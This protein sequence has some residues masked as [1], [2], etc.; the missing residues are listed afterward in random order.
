MKIKSIKIIITLIT[1]ALFG[2]TAIQFYWISNSM[3]LEERIF[4]KNVGLALSNITENLEKE[5]TAQ[6]IIKRIID[7]TQTITKKN[8]GVQIFNKSM[9]NR[10]IDNYNITAFSSNND[11]DKVEVITNVQS[12]K[13]NANSKVLLLTSDI[14]SLILNKNKIIKKVFDDFIINI[15]EEN[16]AE[17]I[18]KK[19]K[20]KDLQRI[21]KKELNKYGIDAKFNFAIHLIKNDSLFFVKNKNEI[22]KLQRTKYKAR[23]F[24]NDVFASPN[25]LIIDFPNKTN[26][27]YKSNWLVLIISVL[28]TILIIS[29]FYVTVKMFLKQKKITEVKNDLLNNITHE[30]KTPIS[31]IMLATDIM[32][33]QLFD[34]GQKSAKYLS[35]IKKENKRLSLIVE[36]ILTAASLE[37]NEIEINT[38]EIELTKTIVEVIEQFALLLDKK[39]GAIITNFDSECNTITMD[40]NHLRLVIANLIDNALKYNINLPEIFISTKRNKEGIEI[41]I[42]DN[43]IGITKREQKK[44]FDTFYRVPTGDI[45]NVKGN[46]VGLSSVKKI[47]ELY[48][49]TLSVE[50]KLNEGSIFKIFLPINN[51]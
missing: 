48:N 14:D 42:K 9:L 33:Y 3:N 24:P 7:S 20:K 21:I 2:L 31:T 4:D 26:Y 8:G 50:S 38:K 13:G 28:L 32:S 40:K 16:I 17:R 36:K 15:S 46:G 25:F 11:S 44:I 10:K 6:M 47:I 49:G 45:H 35:V 1:L 29:L 30:F 12:L 51:L 23:L 34:E 41:I 19:I 43:G 39:N 18:R 27:I 5:E 37:K 22:D